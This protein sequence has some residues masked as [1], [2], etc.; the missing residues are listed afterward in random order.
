MYNK[1]HL[2]I[3]CQPSKYLNNKW[4]RNKKFQRKH[5]E[6]RVN[7]IPSEQYVQM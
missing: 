7:N 5:T 6:Y 3:E 4:Y 2:E 1:K